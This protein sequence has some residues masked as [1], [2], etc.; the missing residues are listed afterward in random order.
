MGRMLEELMR[1]FSGGMSDSSA[2]TAYAPNEAAL[3]YNGRIRPDAT[4]ET[5]GGS[6][7]T[8]STAL[9]SGAQGYGGTEFQ[10]ATGDAQWVV[11]VGD[12]AYYSTDEGGTWTAM[13]TALPTGYWSL[14][15]FRQGSTN[16]LL[17]ANGS[18]V[19][20]WDGTTWGTA[21]GFPSGVKYL[22]TFNERVYYAGHSGNTLVGTKIAD[23]T[24]HSA[25]DGALS[26]NIA[27]HDGDTTISGLYQIGDH[28]L[29]FKEDST[30]YVDGYG[31]SDIIVATGAKG[32]SRSVGC[33]AF[34]SIAGIGDSGVA[35]L[36]KRGVELYAGGQIRLASE[37]VRGFFDEVGWEN[38][39]A[40]Q[41]TPVALY[42]PRRREYW[43]GLPG[44]GTQNS[45]TYVLNTAWA[46]VTLDTVNTDTGFTVFTDDDGYLQYREDATGSQVK[47]DSDG[48]LEVASGSEPGLF[49]EISAD[50]Y[51]E[52]LSVDTV[53]AALFVADRDDEA[54]VPIGV[55]YDGFVRYLD[56]GDKDDVLPDNTGGTGI[57]FRLRTR[58]LLFGGQNA[59]HRKRGRVVDLLGVSGGDT[60]ATVLLLAD[61][62][63]A[64]SKS[65]TVRSSTGDQPTRAKARV[66]GRGRTL[67]VEIQSTD[68]LEVAGVRCAA[69]ILREV[70]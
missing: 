54:S 67:Q 62:E 34:R 69:E 32:A 22:Q 18:T 60:T 43:L 5:R 8:H 31:N 64:S 52:T 47:T 6:Q 19:Y 58:P 25:A 21:S 59:F 20:E 61:G 9:N 49:L 29:V 12:A 44:A 65:V 30:A 17:C 33:V 1:D 35:W 36:S 68:A 39:L 23:R 53:S 3:I 4:V 28:L 2:A 70:V 38:I 40:S 66:N 57:G 45:S 24:T 37:K 15:T 13:A 42:Y 11:F 14:T 51:L 48:Y 10:P 16:Y 46:A 56:V 7:R 63:E 55:G 50:G 41:G 26:L 27:T